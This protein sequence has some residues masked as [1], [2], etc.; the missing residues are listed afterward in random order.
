MDGTGCVRFPLSSP[1]AFVD[2][3]RLQRSQISLDI[4]VAAIGTLSGTGYATRIA[5][6]LR[7]YAAV[8][9]QIDLLHARNEQEA[10]PPDDLLAVIREYMPVTILAPAPRDHFAVLPPL[11]R[12]VTAHLPP[13]L[14]ERA[15]D[16]AQGE[17]SAVWPAV[18]GVRA[19]RRVLV[20]HDDDS[21]RYAR[22][23]RQIRDP[24]RKLLRHAAAAKYARFQR[25][26]IQAADQVWFVSQAEMARMGDCAGRRF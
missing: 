11:A 20:L 19:L 25:R 14:A 16:S 18:A 9:W 10:P 3:A 12:V 4:F 2:G 17:S 8:G 24:R 5:S 22:I 1:S 23:A 26:A 6:M 7:A 21:T 15:Y 13:G